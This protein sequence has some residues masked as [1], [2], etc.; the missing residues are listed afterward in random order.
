MG[1][2]E[3]VTPFGHTTCIRHG[4]DSLRYRSQPK[5]GEAQTCKMLCITIQDEATSILGACCTMLYISS[6]K[7]SEYVSGGFAV[8]SSARQLK[9]LT[10]IVHTNIMR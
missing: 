4:A 9:D 2:T 1:M 3:K 10:R 6:G 5:K 8:I 7:D